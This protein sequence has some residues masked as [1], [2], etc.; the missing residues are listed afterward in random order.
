MAL[1][2]AFNDYD[3]IIVTPDLNP[4]ATAMFRQ[5]AMRMIDRLATTGGVVD[6]DQGHVLTSGDLKTLSGESL[7]VLGRGKRRA[8]S[9]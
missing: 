2:V 5:Q 9:S 6:I 3:A 8:P 4:V 7:C 1:G